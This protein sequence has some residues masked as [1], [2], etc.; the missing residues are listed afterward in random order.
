MRHA[1]QARPTK[2][3]LSLRVYAPAKSPAVRPL[4]GPFRTPGRGAMPISREIRRRPAATRPVHSFAFK[5]VSAPLSQFAVG[6][7]TALHLAGPG[8]G[9]SKGRAAPT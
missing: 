5:N 2:R 8:A 1:G 6:S 4:S 7:F 3:I 9:S